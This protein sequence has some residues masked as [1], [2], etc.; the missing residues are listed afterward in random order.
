MLVNELTSII[1]YFNFKMKN[2]VVFTRNTSFFY[3]FAH[4]KRRKKIEKK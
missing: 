2:I 3:T 1:K 4:L